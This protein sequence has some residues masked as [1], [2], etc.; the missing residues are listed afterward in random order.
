MVE[1][2]NDGIKWEVTFSLGAVIVSFTE[3]LLILHEVKLVPS[4]LGAG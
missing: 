3:E 2:W 4:V 1:W